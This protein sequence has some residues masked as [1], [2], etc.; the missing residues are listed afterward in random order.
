MDAHADARPEQRPARRLRR[1]LPAAGAILALV[2]LAGLA[3]DH[4]AEVIDRRNAGFC[5]KHHGIPG[6]VGFEDRTWW[7]IGDRCFLRMT[8]GTT[9]VHEPGWSLTAL[10]AG[11]SAV[12]VAGF[13][14]PPAWLWRRL[15]WAVLIPAVPVAL[16]VLAVVQPASLSRLVAITSVSLGFGSVMGAVTAA[17]VWYVVRGRVLATVLGSWLA[18]SVIVLLQGRDA[19][20]P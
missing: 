10:L 19:I 16:L 1:V 15:A 17:G 18:W 11:W 5:K 4:S 13:L 20:A 2:V 9:R 3:F 14:A 12:G 7:P 6:A 8:D